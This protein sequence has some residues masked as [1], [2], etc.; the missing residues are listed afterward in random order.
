MN[1]LSHIH[2]HNSSTDSSIHGIWKLP[3]CR[4][5]KIYLADLTHNWTK[6]KDYWSIPL[7]IGTIS[8][9]CRKHLEEE[10]AEWSLFKFPNKLIAAIEDEAPDILG[11]SHYM[12]NANLIRF[13][14]REVKRHFPDTLVVIGGPN[15]TQ[16]SEWM[17]NF[18]ADSKADFHTSWAGED[19]F[20]QIV[21]ARMKPNA[22]FDSIQRDSNLHGVWRLN[23]DNGRAEEIKVTKT[24]KNLDDIPS[25]YLN[26]SLD[27]FLAD[28]LTPMLETTRGCPFKCT[29]CDWGNATMGKVTF[30]S[31][32]RLKQDLDYITAH[33][34]NE[35]LDIA[36]ANFGILKKQHLELSYYIKT[37]SQRTGYPDRIINTWN[38][39]KTDE[40]LQMA[41][42]LKEICPMTTSSQS[43]NSDVLKNIKRYN[44]T[45]KEWLKIKPFCA[46]RGITM[47]CELIFGLPGETMH[48]Y[49]EG[50][51]YL[52]N[53]G[54]DYV[55]MNSLSLLEGSE[56][57]TAH[58]RQ[59]YK[60]QT[61]FR[62]LENSY[63]VYWGQPV[64]E[65]E[66][67]VVATQDI[68]YED[69]F[70]NRILSWLIQMSW[71]LRHQDTVIRLLFAKL[72]I[73][74]LDFFVRVIED[75]ETA[76]KI[77][78]QIF[79]EFD[80]DAQTELYPSPE[81]LVAHYT[82]KEELEHLKNGGF[83]R[84]NLAYT[85]RV[86]V[87]CAREIV[88]YY[89]QVAKSLASDIG[90]LDS[91]VERMIDDC[92]AFASQRYIG[93]EDCFTLA[94]NKMP[95]KQIE[96]FF[97]AQSFVKP[98]AEPNP[99]VHMHS[100]PLTLQFYMNPDQAEMIRKYLQH[101]DYGNTNP[102]YLMYK[103]QNPRH[104]LDKRH[105]LFQV[106]YA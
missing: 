77:V 10:S 51:R 89:G 35:Q 39:K 41:D 85:G 76:P 75:R 103:L 83:R 59:I 12:W 23:P 82:Q 19:P 30:Y 38:Q 46:E 74:P 28:G 91:T 25:P 93:V 21:K 104:G 13:I 99:D 53:V 36:D 81:A 31:I 101:Y 26:H 47:Y 61:K 8:S 80:M 1:T 49:L 69:H 20:L 98:G 29:F 33:T 87:E 34:K 94:T 48:S 70:F 88:E 96:V 42:N 17:Q 100:K 52:F 106:K 64:I 24:I 57:N 102:E 11:L 58:E 50:V 90:K 3:E 78:R 2:S 22:S 5:L 62:L 32:E 18:F 40:M 6:S 97:D 56:M 79:D 54:A 73:N 72:A 16:T 92:V 67:I 63:G 65:Y 44:I 4:P 66:E 55:S 9:Y 27:H 105:L 7:G 15:L 86:S 71:N 43:L 84:L 68:S 60:I 95:E 37:L 14:S 45:H